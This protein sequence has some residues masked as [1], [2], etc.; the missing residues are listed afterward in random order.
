MTMREELKCEDCKHFHCTGYHS[1][2]C[3]CRSEEPEARSPFDNICKDF[4]QE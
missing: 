2:Y 1:Y 3:F 4:E